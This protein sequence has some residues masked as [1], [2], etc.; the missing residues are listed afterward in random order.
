MCQ[1]PSTPST[2]PS[3]HHSTNPKTSPK[4]PFQI[5]LVLRLHLRYQILSLGPTN[6]VCHK[7]FCK[8]S[9]CPAKASGPGA[10]VQ[11]IAQGVTVTVID[12]ICIRPL[13][14]RSIYPLQYARLLLYRLISIECTLTE[15][16]NRSELKAEN[17]LK[18]I[19]RAAPGSSRRFSFFMAR[20]TV[21][22]EVYH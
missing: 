10:T 7:F 16:E 3:S 9:N 11:Q 12:P 6:H 15:K 18:S 4:A 21:E 5:Y 1:Q 13:E 19:E 14:M 22:I 17:L 2:S 20:V 8:H